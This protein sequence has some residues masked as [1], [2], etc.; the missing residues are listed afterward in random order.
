MLTS[1]N[2]TVLTYATLHH[3]RKAVASEKFSNK[4]F[5]PLKVSS[6][7]V[8]RIFAWCRRSFLV[9][10]K[11]NSWPCGYKWRPCLLFLVP[12]PSFLPNRLNCATENTDNSEISCSHLY[13]GFIYINILYISVNLYSLGEVR[14]KERCRGLTAVQVPCCPLRSSDKD[15]RAETTCGSGPASR[16]TMGITEIAF[17]SSVV[18]F[19]GQCCMF[20]AWQDESYKV[21]KYTSTTNEQA[22]GRKYCLKKC[23]QWLIQVTR[24]ARGIF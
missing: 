15:P 16:F 11:L 20:A 19:R 10:K 21:N 5:C 1:E 7:F 17:W 18:Y 2:G 13:Q 14:S 3:Q 8:W 22:N 4:I 9:L 6:F 23:F 12:C 24:M